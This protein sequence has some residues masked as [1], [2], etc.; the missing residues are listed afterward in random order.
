MKDVPSSPCPFCGNASAVVEKSAPHV[1]EW[2][3]RTINSMECKQCEKVI[4]NDDYFSTSGDYEYET[5]EE[6]L[7][8]PDSQAV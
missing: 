1:H 5:K 8:P 7:P 2:S 6:T 4:S 3:R